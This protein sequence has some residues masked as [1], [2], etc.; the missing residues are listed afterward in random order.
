M[1]TIGLQ[2]VVVLQGFLQDCRVTTYM[3][4]C[5]LLYQSLKARD[6]DYLYIGRRV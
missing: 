2:K 6:G 5:G 4:V 3:W 1:H